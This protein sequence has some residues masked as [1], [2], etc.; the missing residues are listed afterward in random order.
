ML[1]RRA[2]PS[3]SQHRPVGRICPVISPDL[4][5]FPL[6]NPNFRH[7]ARVW[8]STNPSIHAILERPPTTSHATPA[9]LPAAGPIRFTSAPLDVARVSRY[10]RDRPLSG[11]WPTPQRACS[12]SSTRPRLTGNLVGGSGCSYEHEYDHKSSLERRASADYADSA[13]GAPFAISIL[14]IEVDINPRQLPIWRRKPES[15]APHKVRT[16][17]KSIGLLSTKSVG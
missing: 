1:S 9:A 13:D 8:A 15:S 4:P 10:R 12:I 6:T 3:T 16:T 14:Y 5:S 7:H 17:L 2:N 11:W